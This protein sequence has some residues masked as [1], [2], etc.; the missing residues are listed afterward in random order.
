MLVKRCESS[1]TTLFTGPY[2]Q[3]KYKTGLNQTSKTALF[4]DLKSCVLTDVRVQVPPRVLFLY[5]C[6]TLFLPCP[7]SQLQSLLLD[8]WLTNF[9]QFAQAVV[10]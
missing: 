4:Q 3:V 6:E 2:A 5:Q 10:L 9:A 1:Q 8:C 7:A